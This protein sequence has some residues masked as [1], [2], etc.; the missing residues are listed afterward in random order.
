[1]NAVACALAPKVRSLEPFARLRPKRRER[2]ADGERV[3]DLTGLVRAV[4]LQRDRAAF[5]TIFEVMAPR[6]KAFLRRGGADDQTAEDVTQDVMI[7]VWQR[8]AMYD[9]AKASVSTWVFTIARN[10]RIDLIRR[11][12]RPEI[13]VVETEM[14]AEEDPAHREMEA[15]LDA[16]ALASAMQRLPSDQK[17][18]LELAFF[19]DKTHTAI[20]ESL[21]L[22]LGTVKSRLRLGLAKL[23]A[24]LGDIS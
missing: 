18:L 24:A 13:D 16:P 7:T 15:R 6:V 14:R 21:G 12:R 1:M 4:A 17:A 5:C 19:E 3:E 23:R 20:A 8:A 9:P 2:C 10:R 11:A 22:P